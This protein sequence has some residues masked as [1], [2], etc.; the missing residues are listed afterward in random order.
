MRKIL[1]FLILSLLVISMASCDFLGENEDEHVHSFSDWVIT[2]NADCYEDGM[3]AR[4]CAICDKSQTLPIPASHSFGE[5]VTVTEATCTSDGKSERTCTACGKKTSES[6]PLLHHSWS[7]W[8]TVTEATCTSDGENE[9]T[10]V[11]CGEKENASVKPLPHSWSNWETTVAATC[12][13]DGTKERIC[14]LCKTTE[15]ETI[16]A[17]HNYIDGVCTVCDLF[18]L[19]NITLPELPLTAYNSSNALSITSL[20]IKIYNNEDVRIYYCAEKTADSGT[21]YI[22]CGFVW[23]LYDSRGFVVASEKIIKSNLALGDKITGYFNVIDLNE[24]DPN[25]SYTLVITDA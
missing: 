8:E 23:K 15:A 19:N 24:V 16:A 13:D 22:T 10:C 25:E 12:T 20:E 5:W 4:I 14:A 11:S 17:S 21:G 3:Q 9:R 18:V 7:G 2:K 1:L 6:I